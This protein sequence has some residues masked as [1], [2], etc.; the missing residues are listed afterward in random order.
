MFGME[1]VLG[2]TAVYMGVSTWIVF[3]KDNVNVKDIIEKNLPEGCEFI[4]KEENENHDL[5][6]FRGVYGVDYKLDKLTTRLR[7]HLGCH[8]NIDF[9]KFIKIKVYKTE[10]PKKALLPMFDE[11]DNSKVA[12]G[13]GRDGVVYHDFLLFPHMV[14]AGTTGYGK[15]N[16]IKTLIPQLDGEIIILDLKRSDDYEH[17]SAYDISDAVGVFQDIETRFYEKKDQHIF[18]I[19]DEAQELIPPDYLKKNEEKKPYL[20]CQKMMALIGAQG[21]SNKVHLIYG[22]QYP[23]ADVIPKFVKQNAETRVV[24]RLPTQVASGVAL[25]EPGAEKLP[26]GQKGRALYKTD[27]IEEI[28]TFSSEGV[29]GVVTKVRTSEKTRNRDTITVG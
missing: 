28:Q 8:V 14:V 3:R 9:N 2:L 6:L 16:F 1:W 10:L 27:R 26:R 24:F 18:V 29:Q 13:K 23:T 4:D 15:T 21:R 17:A 22:T 20:Y 19:V 25:D 12:I 11:K 5:Y 7:G